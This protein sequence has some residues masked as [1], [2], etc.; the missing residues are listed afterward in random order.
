MSSLGSRSLTQLAALA[1]A[2]SGAGALIFACSDD[3]H[4]RTEPGQGAISAGACQAAPGAL[5]EPNCDNSEKECEPI[6]GCSIDEAACGSASTC[7]P[8][9]TNTGK[10]LLD[11]RL[12]R[13]NV[14]APAALAAPFIQK[15]IVTGGIDFDAK[16]C[17]EGGKGLFTWLMR[18]D[19]TAN[20]LITGGAPPAKDPFGSGFCFANFNALG[21]AVAPVSL[22]IQFTGETF[23]TL[24]KKKLNVPIFLSKELDSVV[25]LPITDVTIEGVTLSSDGNCIGSFNRN[26]LAANCSD[27]PDVCS[28]WNTAGSIGGY[29][30][31]EEADNVF[32]KD[33]NRSLCVVLS[34]GSPAPDLKCERENGQIKFKGDYCSQTKQPGGCQDSAW[35]AATFAAAAVKIYESNDSSTPGCSGGIVGTDD[36][37]ADATTTDAAPLGDAETDAGSDGS[38]D[39]N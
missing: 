11:L 9:S 16:Q 24:E 21:N 37:G 34:Q 25:V 7:L 10:S 27:N 4:L 3:L 36:A 38:P 22:P 29:I 35:L 20:T 17:G 1:M 2:I 19:R 31:L 30:T 8:T 6:A 28:K 12:R 15:T 18:V 32:I 13:L 23:K 5:P 14:A 39:A 26:A 33:L